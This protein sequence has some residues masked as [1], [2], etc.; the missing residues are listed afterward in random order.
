MAFTADTFVNGFP[1]ETA[2][3][4]V[5][6]AA[7][8]FESLNFWEYLNLLEV[9][10]GGDSSNGVPQ[11]AKAGAKAASTP[12]TILAKNALVDTLV[13]AFRAAYEGGSSF[14]EAEPFD[15][16]MHTAAHALL[17]LAV[18]VMADFAA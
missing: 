4:D 5:G 7:D 16:S 2:T 8:K 14:T 12:A 11:V 6:M 17:K 1:I 10:A 15:A 13:L 9:L 3:R 18:I